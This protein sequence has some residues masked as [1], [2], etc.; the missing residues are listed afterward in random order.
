MLK[1]S[2]FIIATFRNK[3]GN[4]LFDQVYRTRRGFLQAVARGTKDEFVSAIVPSKALVIHG[5]KDLDKFRKEKKS[6]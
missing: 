1:S 5:L 6:V 2:P 3:G 4:Y